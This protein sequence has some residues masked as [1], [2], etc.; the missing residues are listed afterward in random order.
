M[1][2]QRH[3]QIV[4]ECVCR[5]LS[6]PCR[7]FTPLAAL[8][9]ST[10]QLFQLEPLAFAIEIDHVWNTFAPPNDLVFELV[11]SEFGEYATIFKLY[12]LESMGSGPSPAVNF[13]NASVAYLP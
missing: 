3:T 5:L 12:Q 10:V 7:S 13:E 2:H 9:V 6:T 4:P 8:T 11:P 1:G